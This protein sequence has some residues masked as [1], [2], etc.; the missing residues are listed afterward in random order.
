[1]SRRLTPQERLDREMQKAK[2]LGITISITH[3]PAA[4]ERPDAMDVMEDAARRAGI[5]EEPKR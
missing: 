2:S 1:V 3:S 5:Y 4:H